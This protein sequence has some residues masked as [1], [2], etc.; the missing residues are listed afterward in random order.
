MAI[1]GT[2]SLHLVSCIVLAYAARR[3]LPL[4]LML[5]FSW[6]A[7]ARHAALE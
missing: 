3:V 7:P 1:G 6:R 5:V 2:G 4:V